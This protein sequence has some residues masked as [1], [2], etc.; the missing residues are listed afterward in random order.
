[1]TTMKELKQIFQN[2]S[3][4]LLLLFL[5]VSF[6][7]GSCSKETPCYDNYLSLAFVGFSDTELDTIKIVKLDKANDNMLDTFLINRTSVFYQKT[8][9][10]TF[11]S[12]FKVDILSKKNNWTIYVPTL[13]KTFRISDIVNEAKTKKCGG[14][15]SLDCFPCNNKVVS[16][17][18]NSVIKV[19]NSIPEV[20]Y[21]Q[22]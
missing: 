22:K 3:L 13:N 4:F 5:L 20:I 15:L 21:I 18:I 7:F 10:T 11:I 12:V 9:D 19:V 16:Y 17:K 1:M 2:N 8:N 6:I 14:L